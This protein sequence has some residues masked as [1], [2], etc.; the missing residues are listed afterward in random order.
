MIKRP[1]ETAFV[2]RGR[3]EPS[4]SDCGGIR[5]QGAALT[6]AVEVVATAAHMVVTRR[7]RKHVGH[8]LLK[9][10]FSGLLPSA[11]PASVGPTDT[12]GIKVQV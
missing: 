1:P 3:S 10:S 9:S 4:F 5:G 7:Q 8:N 6:K 12:T 11:G 2:R